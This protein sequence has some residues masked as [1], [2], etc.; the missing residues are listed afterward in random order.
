MKRRYPSHLKIHTEDSSSRDTL[1]VQRSRSYAGL[2]Q[3]EI[4]SVLK[5]FS[6][7]TGWSVTS[8]SIPQDSSG[9]APMPHVM[10]GLRGQRWRL[11]ESLVQDGLLDPSDLSD[12]PSV[13]MDRAQSLL[14]A[15]ESLVDRL[16]SAEET[17][18]RQEAELATTVGV[19]SHQD[20]NR[21]TADRLESI[22]ES[23]AK[24]IGATAAAVY[25]LDEDT[26]SLKM[27]SCIGLPKSRLTLPPRPL[28]GSLGD[29]EALLGNAVLLTDIEMM[30]EW[31][32]P[33]DF[34][35]AIVAPIGS[36][37]MPYGT[38]WFW[39][40]KNRGYT[41]TQVEIVNLAA[42][43]IMNEIEH[44]LLGEELQ[45]SREIRKQIDTASVTQASMLPDAQRLHE[46]FDVHGWTFQNGSLGG[47]FHQWDATPNR[48][49]G[50]LVGNANQQGPE[51]ALVATSIQSITRMQWNQQASL[52][53]IMQSINDLHW[54]MQDA[55]WKASM[56][57]FYLN[58]ETGYGSLCNAGNVHAFVVSERGFRPIASN[59]SPIGA[60][61]EPVYIPQRFI[62]QPSEIL[63]AYTSDIVDEQVCEPNPRR[64]RS[65]RTMPYSNLNQNSL[66]QIVR[67][68]S[69]QRCSDIAGFL[70][71]T[72]PTFE[73]DRR[74]G[75]DRSLILLK[76]TKKQK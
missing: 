43:R 10:T 22:L 15:I 55:D 66:L 56:A 7:A 64:G 3:D 37:N 71:R 52:A 8:R 51:G 40:E 47:G 42:G 70:A 13:S 75:L 74:N 33:E 24:S 57:L 14:Q 65:R 20:R 54:S 46:N 62:L 23:A 68:M 67:D 31:P 36:Q 53:S 39:S 35:A 72:L 30:P 60:S 73:R 76:N 17:V 2:E 50:L 63:I 59:C 16:E 58:P 25:L 34:G 6:D 69:T 1:A 48:M 4:R 5:S 29:L 12:L 38:V 21:E 61:P 18:R 26:T 41:A 49:L 27:R 28:K 9:S 45:E 32:S 44:S 19:T 11:V